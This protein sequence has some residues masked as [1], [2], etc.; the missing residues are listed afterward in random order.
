MNR[1]NPEY[2]SDLQKRANDTPMSFALRQLLSTI[3][4]PSFWIIVG[5]V[6]FLTALAGPYFTLERLTFPE[7]LVY[8][9]TT[10]VLSALVMTFLSSLAYRL[11]EAQGR[12]WA[13]G[14][15]IAGLMDVLPVIGSIYLAEGVATGFEIGWPD[16][17]SFGTLALY[18]VPSV[19]A[20][21]LVV[22][23]VITLQ[24]QNTTT[25]SSDPA[26]P[27]ATLLQNKLPHH[28]GQEIVS[29]QA[30]DHYVE[31]TTPKGKAMVL[32]RLGDAVKDLEPLGGMQVHRS[33]WVNLSHVSAIEKTP[34][35]PEIIL[36]SDQ[37]LL[38]GR[39]FRTAF[40][41]AIQR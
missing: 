40:R 24:Y 27:T 41:R 19:V 36:T 14:S 22:N 7:R 5:S 10:I 34:S 35:G 6:V 23:W 12:N 30:Q 15:C 16:M 28:L 39:S 3:C 37:R 18:V 31:V 20:V 32:M 9:A 2:A 38:V 1:S 25:A 4:Q 26:P 21:T 17:I 8:W 29:V 11:T 13:V 33:W